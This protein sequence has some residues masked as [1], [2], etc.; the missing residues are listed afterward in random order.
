LTIDLRVLLFT[1]GAAVIT[2]LLF[3][4]LPALQTRSV[5]LRSSI[6]LGGRSVAGG[7]NRLRQ[8]L[9]GCEVALTVVLVAGAGLVIRSLIYLETLPPGFDATNVM[10]AKVSLDDARYRDAAAFHNLIDRSVAAM[11]AIPGVEHVAV[12][13][14]VP[15]E[16]GLNDGVKILDGKF[17]GKEWGSSLSYVSPEFFQSLRIPVLAGRAFSDSDTST[18]QPVAVVNVDFARA[19]FDEASPIGRHIQNSGHVFTIVGVVANVAKRPGIDSDAPLGTE[20]VFYLPDTQTDQALVNI[21]HI[22]LQ[23]SWIVRTARPVEGL[24]AAMQ[25]ALAQ[26]DPNLPFSGFYSMQD[27]LATNL[28]YQRV[29]VALLSVLGGLAILLSAVGIYGLV[30]NLIVQRTREIGIR[31]ALGSSI[32]RAMLDVG[33]AGVVAAGFGVVAGLALSFVVLRALRSELYGVRDYDPLT[34][35][36]VPLILVVIAA[37]AS[38][39][40]SLRITRIDP[41]ETLRSE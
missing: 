13:L 23:P 37:G 34:L 22:W 12:A 40:P 11:H 5:D 8:A 18:S 10:T 20:P 28:S 27:L 31:M 6:A 14:S 4:G 32:Q 29:E 26:V 2:S 17:A 7:S 30:S 24:T 21:A 9:I 1:V 36:L 33:S 3:G 41:S 19:F 16:R 15:Y 39:L 38:F 25:Q 35:T